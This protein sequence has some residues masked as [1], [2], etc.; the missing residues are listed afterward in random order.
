MRRVRLLGVTAWEIFGYAVLDT[1]LNVLDGKIGVIVPDDLVKG[2]TFTE[3]LKNALHC[4]PC[5][6]Y[7]GLAEVYVGID[8]DS[9]HRR[10][11]PQRSDPSDIYDTLLDAFG[12][13][14]HPD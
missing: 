8:C 4:D 6:G 1:R 13:V 5:A 14:I 12:D 9:L 7:A 10:T 3:Q 11:A 2:E